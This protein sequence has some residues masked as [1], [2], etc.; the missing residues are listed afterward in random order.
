MQVVM[1]SIDVVTSH[2][3]AFLIQ[4]EANAF[5]DAGESVSNS[6]VTGNQTLCF[7]LVHI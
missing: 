6:K 3:L 5:D 4:R 2:E 1:G 7:I